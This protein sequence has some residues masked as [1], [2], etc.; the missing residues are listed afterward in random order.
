MA[1]GARMMP[2]IRKA[3]RECTDPCLTKVK[4]MSDAANN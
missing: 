3:H 2:L 1:M 4:T